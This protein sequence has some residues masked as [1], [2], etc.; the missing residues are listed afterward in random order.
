VSNV[1]E[2]PDINVFDLFREGSD[3]A[4]DEIYNRY[5]EKLYNYAFHRTRS[6]DIAFEIVQDIF[7]SLWTRREVIQL[8]SSVSGYLFASVRFQILNHIKNSKLKEL[9]LK[10][11]IRFTSSA[12]NSNEESMLVQDLQC[13]LEQSIDELPARCRE[14][15][16]LSMLENWSIEKIA[17]QLNISH[18]TV[19][20]Q[21]TLGRKH[22][23][24]SLGDFVMLI[25]IINRIL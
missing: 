5:W 12:D 17:V 9:Y 20:N 25:A 3:K 2:Y 18:R 16:R 6:K 15:T 13:A 10:D 22:L 8:Q 4:F 24:S 19:E 7:V 21:L 1:S 23:K 14:I 11:Y